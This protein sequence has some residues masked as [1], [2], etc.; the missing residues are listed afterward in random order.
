MSLYHNHVGWSVVCDYGISWS[1]SLAFCVR[2]LYHGVVIGVLSSLA[3]NLLR[4]KMLVV[5]L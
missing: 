4:K 5:V 2:S 1:F 3:I